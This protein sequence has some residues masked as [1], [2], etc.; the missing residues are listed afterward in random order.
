M[1]TTNKYQPNCPLEERVRS[2]EGDVRDVKA[3]VAGLYEKVGGL[4]DTAEATY[5][6]VTY[7]GNESSSQTDDEWTFPEDEE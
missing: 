3:M 1:T 2:I 5:K 7:P 4:V 6:N